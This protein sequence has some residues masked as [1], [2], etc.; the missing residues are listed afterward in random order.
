MPTVEINNAKVDKELASYEHVQRKSTF[1]AVEY[2]AYMA[3]LFRF[4]GE[5]SWRVARDEERLHH[6]G[7]GGSICVTLEQLKA[8]L[9]FPMHRF[10]W[11]VV[12]VYFKCS[13]SQITPNA[14]RA[15]NWYIASCAALGKQP[16]LKVFFHLFNT[17]TSSAKPF[18]ELPFTNKNSMIGKALGDYMA[19]DFPNNNTDWQYEFMVILGGELPWMHNM[20]LKV[21]KCYHAPREML[22]TEELGTLVR[23][24]KAWKSTWRK[25]DFYENGR[26][27]L[28]LRK[29]FCL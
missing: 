23:I 8:G 11:D 18:V 9:R 7:A 6:H 21:E 25:N 5:Y 13:I 22:S 2:G 15:I 19:F 16:T 17:K 20:V 29:C 26:L 10:M 24:T 28:Y 12:C 3:K 14:I 27:Q 1:N 4:G